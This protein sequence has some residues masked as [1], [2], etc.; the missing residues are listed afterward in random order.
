MTGNDYFNTRGEAPENASDV[1]EVS[2]TDNQF[3]HQYNFWLRHILE[4]GERRDD[5]T[6]TGTISA[7][8]DVNMKFDLRL[9]FPAITGKRLMFK[10][11]KHETIDW[12]LKGKADLPSLKALGVNIWDRNV[13]PGTEVYEGAELSWKERLNY[14][15]D[16]QKATFWEWAYEVA[17]A[18]T[19]DGEEFSSEH[20]ETFQM[21]L[22]NWGVPERAL[23]DGYL[24]PLYGEQWR[25]WEDLRMI[26]SSELY[27]DAWA[28]YGSRGFEH[29]PF[30]NGRGW[31]LIRREIDQIAL[32]EE[33]IK[34]EVLFHQGKIEKHS[35]GRRII[36]TGWNVAQLDEMQL[37]PC[38]TMAQ[39]Y[40]SSQTDE[41]G[42]HFLDCKL[43]LRSVH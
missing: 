14:C 33:A 30:E 13:K 39:W 41:Y 16:N 15:T 23:S 10:T 42:Q 17:G 3:D 26:R 40:I 7:F 36:L 6:K 31:S 19:E 4:H 2:A 34:N 43:Y 11:M 24:G 18:L 8:G 9:N 22:N 20:D 27:E 12:M 5:R 28:K 37:P 38:H 32:V 25:R 35:A 1:V 29:T 21:K